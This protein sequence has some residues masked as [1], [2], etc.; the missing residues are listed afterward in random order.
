MKAA[1]SRNLHMPIQRGDNPS[2]DQ[3][4]CPFCHLEKHRILLESEFA[5]AFLDGFPVADGHALVVPKRHVGSLFDLPNAELEAVWRLVSSIRG[6]MLGELKP[7]AFN[8]GVNDG[9]AA[10]QTVMHA[11]VHLIPRRNGDTAHPRGGIPWIMPENA[12]YWDEGHR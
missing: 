12:R 2:M 7:D 1:S 6:K 11:H 5:A 9:L 8:I 10:G 3:N 4:P